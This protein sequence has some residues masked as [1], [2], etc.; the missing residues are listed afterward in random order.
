MRLS[1]R[2]LRSFCGFHCAADVWHFCPF[3]VYQ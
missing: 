2:T 1:I 3:L